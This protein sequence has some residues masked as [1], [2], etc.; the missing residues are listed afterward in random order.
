MFA[1]SKKFLM[2][3]LNRAKFG[4][5]VA[6]DGVDSLSTE[7][8]EGHFTDPS[9]GTLRELVALMLSG[10]ENDEGQHGY[11]GARGNIPIECKPIN[12][13]GGRA[14]A[15]GHGHFNEFSQKRHDDALADGLIM[16]QSQFFFGDC[17]WVVEFP[18]SW[19]KE[20]MVKE[21]EIC[22]SKGRR[23]VARFNYLDWIDC[24]DLQVKYIN[25]EVIREN[26]LNIVGG[27]FNNRL[28]KKLISM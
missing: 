7:A 10:A 9:T 26:R 6:Y 12:Y 14:N 27:R 17:G 28:Y 5:K 20:K 11:D 16:Q 23:I 13:K 1:Y 18:Y 2:I 15:N 4:S 19:I 3:L 22:E 21:I 24:P 8:I 25:K